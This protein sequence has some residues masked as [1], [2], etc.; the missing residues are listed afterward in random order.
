[1]VFELFPS[2][3][4]RMI[5]WPRGS[6]YILYFCLYFIDKSVVLQL[7]ML[8]ESPGGWEGQCLNLLID[9]G[10][11]IPTHNSTFSRGTFFPLRNKTF[12]FTVISLV[13][14]DVNL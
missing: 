7:F 4:L 13:M 5:V 2:N 14:Y 12:K 1:M 10:I 11:N 6:L 9:V 8:A 3:R